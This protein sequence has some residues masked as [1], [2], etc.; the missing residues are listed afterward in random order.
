MRATTGGYIEVVDM[1]LSVGANV[2]AVDDVSSKYLIILLHHLVFSIFLK[3]Y[4]T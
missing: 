3:G 2:N 4:K 1:L